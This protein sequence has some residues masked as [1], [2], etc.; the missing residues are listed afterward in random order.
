MFPTPPR[1]E[2]CLVVCRTSP[3]GCKGRQKWPWVTSTLS[4]PVFHRTT[5]TQDLILGN[6][7]CSTGQSS[8]PHPSWVALL[9]TGKIKS[10]K[11]PVGN[12]VSGCKAASHWQTTNTLLEKYKAQARPYLTHQAGSYKQE[13]PGPKLSMKT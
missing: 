11:H 12:C 3:L 13:A 9:A 5:Q 1:D 10:E 8:E 7:C 2:E 6:L 4:S